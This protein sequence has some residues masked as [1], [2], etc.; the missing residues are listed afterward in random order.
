MKTIFRLF[1]VLGFILSISS[2]NTF[3]QVSISTNGACADA[4]AMLDV[5]STTKG[6]LIPRM[7]ASQ[8]TGI[9]SAASGLLVYQTDGTAGFYYHNGTAWTFLG[10]GD[11]Y[12]SNVI[13]MDGNAYPTVRIGNQE[14]MAK[15]LK[16]T[17]YRNG[18]AIPKITDNTTWVG[19]ITG[20]RCYYDNDSIT[21]NPVYGALYNWYAVND[22]RNLCPPGWHMPSDYEW[23]TLAIYLGGES[24]AGGQMKTSILWNSPNTGA[25]NTSGFSGLPGG[26]RRWDGVTFLIG[27]G[28]YWWL[29]TEYNTTFAWIR[30]LIS[31]SSDVYSNYMPKHYGFSVRCVRD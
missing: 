9:S 22:S 24:V 29:A 16:V 12:S 6:M 28:G 23:T 20:A 14:W 26:E 21:N 27:Y 3:S 19:L 18:D 17:H 15:N 1:I 31:N 4:S 13:D 8:R 30:A 11:G 2:L 5:K 25:I 10:L 7:T